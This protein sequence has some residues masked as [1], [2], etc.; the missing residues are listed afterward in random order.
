M[1]R[2]PLT[3]RTLR[4]PV[5]TRALLTFACL[6]PLLV[7]VA[8]GGG[9]G[10]GSSPTAPPPPVANGTAS[11]SGQV[12][13]TG[14]T[15]GSSLSAG[16]SAFATGGARS[17]IGRAATQSPS[18]LAAADSSGSGVTV[19][20]AGTSLS[21][22][23]AADGSFSLSG[24]PQGNITV[25]FETSSGTA[26]VGING[27]QPNES[28][29]IEVTVSGS[30]ASV[31]NI[32]RNG[33]DDGMGGGGSGGGTV[34]LDLE[35]EIDPDSWNLNYDHANGTVEAFIRGT[36]YDKVLLDSITLEGDN[37]DAMPL[38]PVAATRQGDH[39]RA[40]FAKNQVLDLLDD[41]QPG[42]THTVTLAFEVDGVTD[43]QTL[44]DTITIEDDSGTDDGGGDQGGDDGS[45]DQVGNLEL[46]ISPKNWNTNFAGANGS[47]TAFVR[48][49][50][51]DK[52]D[53][54]SIMLSGD[55]SEADPLA[56]ST[57]RLEG[58]H[59]RAQFPKNQVLDLIDTPDPGTEH[60]VTLSLTANDGADTFELQ[61]DVKIVGKKSGDDG[62][63]DGE[64]NGGDN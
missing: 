37:A 20:I 56:A 42:S 5:P 45:G 19:Q 21:T 15:G 64:D 33:S 24:V 55:N 12:S 31:D 51:L 10:G 26:T 32:D 46:Q 48:G 17:G 18:A 36:G 41:P 14:S 23:A 16:S 6:L 22:V 35:L 53:L 39:V 57:A 29:T 54:D 30:T 59:V 1:S 7:A 63:G 62:G 34:E 47:V 60:T 44:D 4:I 52:I 50:G 13:V 43:V 49:D 11:L 28:I 9:G 40:S 3:P 27:V 2:K 25:M 58:D 61:E 8:C 38:E